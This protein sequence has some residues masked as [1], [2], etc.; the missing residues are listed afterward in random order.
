MHEKESAGELGQDRPVRDDLLDRFLV[1]LEGRL[2]A[3]QSTSPRRAE[4]ANAP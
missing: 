4:L 3:L 1:G 2:T